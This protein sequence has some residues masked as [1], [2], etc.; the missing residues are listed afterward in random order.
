MFPQFSPRVY[1]RLNPHWKEQH[2]EHLPPWE[3]AIQGKYQDRQVYVVSDF[4]IQGE[5]A[6]AHEDVPGSA[7]LIGILVQDAT[8][9]YTHPLL[10]IMNTS[11]AFRTPEGR[12]QDILIRLNTPWLK[13]RSIPPWRVLVRVNDDSLRYEEYLVA[14][15]VLTGYAYGRRVNFPEPVGRK[16]HLACRGAIHIDAQNIAHIVTERMPRTI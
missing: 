14:H 1:F 9:V 12:V 2:N 3:F 13:D 7:P 5:C 16:V 10:A 11:C 6:G 8:L 15:F 4:W